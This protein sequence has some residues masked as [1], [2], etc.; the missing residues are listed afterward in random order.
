MITETSHMNHIKIVHHDLSN[1]HLYQ[2]E[3]NMIQVH[4][5]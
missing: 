5:C 2:N 4:A 1:I 3:L